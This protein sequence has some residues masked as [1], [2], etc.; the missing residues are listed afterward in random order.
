MTIKN[1]I[2]RLPF[3]GFEEGGTFVFGLIHVV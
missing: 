3:S 2:S 1:K